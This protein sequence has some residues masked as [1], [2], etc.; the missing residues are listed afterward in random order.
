MPGRFS[1]IATPGADRIA[2][3]EEWHQTNTLD[4]QKAHD[5][6]MRIGEPSYFQEFGPASYHAVIGFA[7][8]GIINARLPGVCAGT[9]VNLQ[10]TGPCNNSVKGHISEE[11]MSRTPDE[12]LYGSGTWDAFYFTQCYV[13]LG[14][15]DGE[16][17]AFT[18][19]D[20]Q[21]NFSFSN[22][23]PGDWRVTVFDKWNDL[24]VDG[25][26]TPVML[27]NGA[28]VD[29]G[30]IAINQWQSNVFTRTFIDDNQDGVSQ[31]NEAGIP[32]INTSIRYRDGSLA[33]NLV[34]DFTGTANFNETFPL[35]SWYVVETD[36]TRYKNTGIHTVYDAG[37]P[38]DGTTACGQTGYPPCGNS[39][40]GKNLANTYEQ[41]PLPAN[42]SVPGAVY[43][44]NAD[45][46]QRFH[47]EW[48]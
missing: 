40:I 3:G 33:N 44:S 45:C 38:A 16:D 18:K 48:A 42:L 36:T 43:C 41:N 1:I 27:A 30:E 29:L 6:F 4:G 39:I 37:G 11:R 32:L 31:A 10:A 2:R 26:S 12:R 13:S 46:S 47:P 14:D 23:P 15:P 20:A 34:T 35:F 8:P 17:F 21:G 22:L 19:C 24:L 7:N 9:D 25:L 28:S 5:T